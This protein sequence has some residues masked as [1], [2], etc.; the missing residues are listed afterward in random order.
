M[1]TPPEWSVPANLTELLA[2][3]FDV[4]EDERWHPVLLSV[5]GGIHYEGRDIPLT[6]QI[7]F[8]VSE[9]ELAAASAKIAAS[10]F[11]ADGH[12]WA[13]A[14]GSAVGRQHAAL[15]EELHFEDT[16]A[17]TLVVWVESEESCRLLM[18]VVWNLVHAS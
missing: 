13:Q 10:G 14:I 9:P 1:E 17:D 12:G 8:Y 3:N 15:A 18:N 11:E 2:E 4:W 5:L 6:W 16:D 7:E